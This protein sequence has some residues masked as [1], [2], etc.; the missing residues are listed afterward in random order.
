MR[1]PGLTIVKAALGDAVILRAAGELE[2]ATVDSLHDAMIAVIAAGPLPAL[3]FDLRAVTYIDSSGLG[4]LVSAR[5]YLRPWRSEVVVLTE[6]PMLL[7]LLHR[8]GLDQ[9]FSIYPSE[10][11]YLAQRRPG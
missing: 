2:L 8:S 6:Q 4:I 9:S 7:E 10:E 11:A 1:K 3:V 5:R